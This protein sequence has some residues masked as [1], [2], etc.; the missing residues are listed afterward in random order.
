MC[1][2]GI[3]TASEFSQIITPA[4]LELSKSARTYRYR[5]LS[6]RLTGEPADTQDGGVETLWMAR[7]K[8]LEHE[9][10]QA[11]ALL[12]GREPR[13]CGFCW[14]DDKQSGCSPDALVGDDGLLEMKCESL[15]VFLSRVCESGVPLEHWMQVQ[16]E[17]W[18]TGRAWADFVAYYPGLPLH[19]FRATPDAA[20]QDAM[21]AH[22]ATFCKTLNAEHE[23]LISLGY[24]LRQ[25]AA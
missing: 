24:D 3:P 17:L 23:R 15:P 18:V 7:G 25:E 2:I 6:E 5:L 19:I 11:Y 8:T 1:R 14:R 4:K 10:F 13:A 16:G 20:V 21:T 9:A 22:I 12:T